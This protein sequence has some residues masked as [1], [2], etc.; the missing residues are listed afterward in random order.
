MVV[1]DGDETLIGVGVVLPIGEVRLTFARV[2]MMPMRGS[3]SPTTQGLPRWLCFDRDHFLACMRRW[4]RGEELTN[5]TAQV[6]LMG[7]FV[8][9]LRR[10]NAKA[11][12]NVRHQGP[13][14]PL[15]FAGVPAAQDV[16]PTSGV[17]PGVSSSVQVRAFVDKYGSVKLNYEADSD[18][19]IVQSE[20]DI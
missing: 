3:G 2:R 12:R 15:G 11:G 6:H 18:S 20:G 19:N 14:L 17:P 8:I 13:T 10:W 1:E 5:S 7:D 16:A 9:A 4:E